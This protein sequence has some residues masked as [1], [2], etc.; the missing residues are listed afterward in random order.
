MH[1]VQILGGSKRDILGA[2]S[3]AHPCARQC[4][5]IVL[6]FTRSEG[7]NRTETCR[8]SYLQIP[9][10]LSCRGRVSQPC[11]YARATVGTDLNGGWCCRVCSEHERG[12]GSGRSSPTAEVAPFWSQMFPGPDS[13]SG[14]CVRTRLTH[15]APPSKGNLVM[16]FEALSSSLE[17]REHHSWFW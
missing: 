16:S 5:L 14:S 7:P 6:E 8:E 13:D 17:V 15:T 9:G 10:R 2:Y 1:T 4:A 3:M 11:P 12:R